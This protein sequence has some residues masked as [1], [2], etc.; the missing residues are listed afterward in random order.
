MLETI[1]IRIEQG[2]RVMNEVRAIVFDGRKTAGKALDKLED[3]GAITWLDE[4]AVISRG[5][6]GMIR[7]HSTWAQDDTAA[8]AGVGLGALTGGLIGAMMGPQG[9][10]AGAIG[11]GAL[12]G[13]SLGGMLGVTAEVAVGDERLESFASRLKN[14][15]SALVLVSDP[16]RA[17][18]FVS[19]FE[20]Y[21]YLEVVETQLNEH[22]VKAL[23]E[24]LKAE[25]Q[26]SS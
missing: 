23:S 17:T 19:A 15:T 26:R 13:G 20:P 11:A 22:D 10:I 12:A 16:T 5:K 25:R 8:T 24:A 7:V 4:V 21:G 2:G 1:D 14:D 9:A 18:A 6:H 3:E